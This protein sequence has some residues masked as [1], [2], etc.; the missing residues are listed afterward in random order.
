MTDKI[1]WTPWTSAF[2]CCQLAVGVWRWEE[3]KRGFVRLTVVEVFVLSKQ[4]RE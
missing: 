4:W 2:L 1:D 3:E